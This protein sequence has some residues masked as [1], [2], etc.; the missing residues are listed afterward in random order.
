MTQSIV[1]EPRGTTRLPDVNLLDMN[2]KK[3]FKFN[4]RFSTATDARDLQPVEQQ[5]HSV[6][7]HRARS[8]LRPRRE[9]RARADGEVRREHELL[10]RARIAADEVTDVQE[11]APVRPPER[12]T[13]SPCS[14]GL[15]S[16]LPFAV[17]SAKSVGIRASSEF[18]EE[19][20]RE[21]S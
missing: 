15:P 20:T 4:S 1:V 7:Q 17:E 18:S 5:C 9:H 21:S 13:S 2:V 11:R 19:Q 3:V 8:R 16:R 12:L 10:D 14:A 6:A